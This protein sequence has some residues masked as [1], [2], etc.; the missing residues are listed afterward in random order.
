MFFKKILSF[1]RAPFL[2]VLI[3]AVTLICSVLMF[4]LFVPFLNRQSCDRLI[5]TW[6]RI[7]CRLAGIQV[8]LRGIGNLKY[9][10][11]AVIVSNH[12][13]LFDI[14]VLYS[15]LPLS[16]RMAAKAELF[17]IPL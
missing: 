5:R 7:L 1:L 11:T 15:C 6:A 9:I 13:G 2:I 16:F 3:P 12:L 4:S 17:K 10:K 14:P 8:E